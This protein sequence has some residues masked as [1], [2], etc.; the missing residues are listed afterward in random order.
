MVPNVFIT[1]TTMNYLPGF[2]L[3][4]IS[5]GAIGFPLIGVIYAMIRERVA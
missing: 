4:D 2:Y 5:F 1:F 3:E